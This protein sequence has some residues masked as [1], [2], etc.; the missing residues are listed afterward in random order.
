MT[1]SRRTV[2]PDT[3]RLIE[4]LRDTGYSFPGSIADILDNSVVA[5]ADAIHVQVSL[6]TENEATVVITDNGSGM[7]E[8][9]LENAMRYGSKR[10][11]GPNSLSKF[12]LG[13]KT[14][15]TSF[16]RRLTVLSRDTDEGP[17]GFACWDLDEV[18]AVGEW[19]LIIGSA[20]PNDEDLYADSL[21]LLSG[22][23]GKPVT[24]GTVVAWEKVDRLLKTKRGDDPANPKRHL[25]TLLKDLK[26][27]LA[28]VFQRYLDQSDERARNVSLWINGEPVEP[29]DPFCTKWVEP[30]TS[31]VFRVQGET[32]AE[33]AIMLRGFI[34]PASNAIAD[35][36]YRQEARISAKLQGI[37][38]YREGRLIEGPDWLAF[39]ERE[40]HL[41]NLRIEL[42]FPGE[43]DEVFGVD[44]KKST[45][46]LSAELVAYLAQIVAPLRREADNQARSG[47]ART[48][49]G[50]GKG[51]R[52]T[53][54]TIKRTIDSLASA[55]VARGSEGDLHI[56]N[57][58]G[59]VPVADASGRRTGPVAIRITEDNDAPFVDRREILEDGVLWEPF[60]APMDSSASIG[61][62]INAKHDWYRK[63]YMRSAA[64]TNLVQAS[65]YLM[66]ALALAEANNTKMELN[67]V[68]R[69]F[70]IEVGQNLRKLVK[71][72][73]EPDF[74]IEPVE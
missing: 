46:H 72:L 39:G 50:A 54:V 44:V 7:S 63:A 71:D 23:A 66:F 35:D 48:I 13:L 11:P 8:V 49:A 33:A 52:P 53:E 22:L 36:S 62:A 2:E 31:K 56:E 30:A 12:G 26:E 5:G 38:L 57:N 10:Q 27:H 73:P 68:Y 51:T 45:V 40:T 25:N 58:A 55:K 20:E 60:V 65:E 9:G 4:G 59:I 67:D 24:H 3:T 16:C 17:V 34:L 74:E 47:K 70:R 69:E 64:D 14:A 21:E 29:W 43:L 1:I 37:Y 32:G 6:S 15:S 41:N 28:M 19:Q 18:V 42:S 61:V